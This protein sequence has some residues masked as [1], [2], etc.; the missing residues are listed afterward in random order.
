MKPIRLAAL[1][2][3][4]AL[5]GM[6]RTDA[7]VHGW[8]ELRQH[9]EVIRD[10]CLLGHLFEPDIDPATG[11]MY[12]AETLTARAARKSMALALLARAEITNA[13]LTLIRM[14]S[15]NANFDDDR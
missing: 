14:E 4:R 8:R 1:S 15:D 13:E 12:P 7:L 5:F 2:A 3:Y 10:L 6:R 11:Q 9:P